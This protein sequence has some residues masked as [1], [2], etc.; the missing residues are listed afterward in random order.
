MHDGATLARVVVEEAD[1]RDVLP[2]RQQDVAAQLGA[3]QSGSRDQ[4][5]I[6]LSLARDKNPV[7]LPPL[8]CLHL[9]APEDS[10]PDA[11]QDRQ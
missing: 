5:A 8:P 10:H 2:S 1:E 6:R 3:A 7:G 4:D 11:D 9:P